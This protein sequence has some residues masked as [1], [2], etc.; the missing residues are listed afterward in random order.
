[1]PVTAPPSPISSQNGLAYLALLIALAVMGVG[2]ALTGTFWHSV[3][4]RAR[5]E[6]L[7]F[8]GLEYHQA[9]RSY[10]ERSPG[11]K[12]Y[13]RTLKALLRDERFPN[14]MRHLRRPYRAP[15]KPGPRAPDDE[16]PEWG[17]VLGPDKGIMGIYS[18]FRG[19]PQK[20]AN[21]PPQLGW[22]AGKKD[23]AEWQ[24]I[25]LPPSG[26]AGFGVR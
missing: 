21:F 18:L 26:Q 1:M 23:Y 12:T 13:P 15:L 2:M 3:Q 5:E 7:L 19:R 9:I 25:Y 14:L 10:Y 24:F 8:V 20:T 17:L 16:A 22:S 11:P 6:E 4:Q